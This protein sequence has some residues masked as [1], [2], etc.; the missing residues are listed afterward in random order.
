MCKIPSE[1]S[2]FLPLRRNAPDSPVNLFAGIFPPAGTPGHG[3]VSRPFLSV[4]LRFVERFSWTCKSSPVTDKN[5][6]NQQGALTKTS[7]RK[8]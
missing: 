5:R 7:R 6:I 3:K 4:I 2:E 1:K 8:D